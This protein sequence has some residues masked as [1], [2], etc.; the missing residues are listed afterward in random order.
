[1]T[2]YVFIIDLD[3]TIIGN[4]YY[5]ALLFRIEHIL[6]KNNIKININDHLNNA[7]KKKNKLLRPYF[8]FF[9]SEMK[10]RFPNS[11]FYIYTASDK[12]WA[13]REIATI[14]KQ[15]NFK[16]D[17]PIFS[18]S[19]C[20]KGS[21]NCYKK[22]VNKILKKKHKNAE[23]LIIDDNDVFIDY[24][25]N[26]VKC[27]SYNYIYFEDLWFHINEKNLHL[28]E[29]KKLISEL[30]EDNLIAPYPIKCSNMNQKLETY[31]WFADKCISINKTNNCDD[32]FWKN[33]TKIIIKNNITEFNKKSVKKINN[34]FTQYLL[35]KA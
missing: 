10:K 27:P 3:G 26:I 15:N 16:F 28:P 21:D 12:K 4:C 30:N 33:L 22:S 11:Y 24:A 29:V 1:M 31:K 25:D 34:Y 5:Q 8:L 23:I 20:I 7:Y 19:D 35:L 13:L 2:E 9:I 14:E 18:R 6:K 32:N 17:R